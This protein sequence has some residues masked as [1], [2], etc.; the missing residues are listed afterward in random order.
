MGDAQSFITISGPEFLK[1]KLV[2][3]D[4]RNNDKQIL[5]GLGRST[6]IQSVEERK[7]I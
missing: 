3:L 4:A 2:K 5:P 1:E 7:N 6:L